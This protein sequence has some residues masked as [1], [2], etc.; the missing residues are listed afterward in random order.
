MPSKKIKANEN[1]TL[2]LH[3][4]SKAS[5][6]SEDAPTFR[7]KRSIPVTERAKSAF[8]VEVFWR[9]F[10]TFVVELVGGEN[11]ESFDRFFD[12]SISIVGCETVRFS[13]IILCF[14]V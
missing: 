3:K 5:R 13:L 9:R 12:F 10:S 7:Q 11:N 2:E 1:E 4:D 6:L 8:V 14:I